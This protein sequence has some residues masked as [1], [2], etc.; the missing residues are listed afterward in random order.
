[1]NLTGKKKV[2]EEPLEEEHVELSE[3][4]LLRLEKEE[5]REQIRL[6]RQALAPRYA[7]SNTGHN[8]K[9]IE[10]VHAV[11]GMFIKCL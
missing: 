5:V 10:S 8:E 9:P 1:M 2:V 11:K 4:Q 7:Y 3:D 6:M